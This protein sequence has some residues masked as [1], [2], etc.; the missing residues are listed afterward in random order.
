MTNVRQW[1]PVAA[2]F[3]L[4]LGA[5]TAAVAQETEQFDRTVSFHSGGRLKLNTFSGRV[6]ITGTDG[7]DVVIHAVRRG[8]RDRLDHVQID[9][10]VDPSQVS[11]EAN[12]KN[13]SWHEDRD[14]VV[15]TDFDIQVPRQT[16]LD[17]NAF[18]S[19]VEISG[20]SGGQK[21]HT[22]SGSMR[23]TDATGPMNAESF[24]GDIDVAFAGAPDGQI[25]FDSFSG[26]I[27]SSRPIT[28]HSSTRRTRM[29]GELGAGG[30]T[31]FRFKTFSGDVT[32]R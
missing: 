25:D 22:F 28:M 8:S 16:E 32:L 10:Q 31:Q 12:K 17:V 30:D 11:I 2:V 1:I 19:R 13:A 7:N 26:R 4:V 5:A 3:A 18:S 23:V 9:V 27:S 24:S 14:N 15:D 21:L 6:T 29:Q 20:V